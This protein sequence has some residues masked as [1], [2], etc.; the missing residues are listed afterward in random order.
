MKSVLLLSA[1]RR[2]SLLRAFEREVKARSKTAKVF[3]ADL[4]PGLSSAC[5]STPNAFKVP[6]IR[7]DDFIPAV[8][9]A[10]ERHDVGLVVPTID[11]ELLPLA[12]GRARFAERGV[13]AVVSAPELV[14]ACRDKRR[15]SELFASL[16][17]EAPR[18]YTSE[19]I[20]FPCFGKPL[21]GS[22]S[23]NTGVVGSAEEMKRALQRDAKT[24]FVELVDRDA[25]DEYTVDLYYDRRG[26]L[27]C[28]VPRKRIEVRDG[29]VSKG[30]TVRNDLVEYIRERMGTL[31]GAVGCITFQI[32]RHRAGGQF[33]AIEINPRFGGGFPL[34]YAAGG[35]YPGWLLDEYLRGKP[36]DTFDQWKEGLLMLRYDSEVFVHGSAH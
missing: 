33:W 30:I 3:A 12:E 27:R 26:A 8:I 23:I 35:N 14:R 25:T 6:P 24:I 21:D 32:F 20:Q 5:A 16:G 13:T 1:G 19:N 36:V 10:C 29:E 34:T 15:T 17:I 28:V 11:T 18:I 22:R 7:S 31:M 2:V 9:D 4:R